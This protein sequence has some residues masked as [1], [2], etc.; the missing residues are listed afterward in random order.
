METEVKT[1]NIYPDTISNM[2]VMDWEGYATSE[3]FREGTETMLD[4]LIEQRMN[5]VLA[6][7]RTMVLIDTVDQKW[8]GTHFLPRAIRFGF[9]ACA[10]VTPT[11]YFNK[12]AVETISF[13]AEKEKLQIQFFDTAEEGKIWLDSLEF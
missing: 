9:K 3:Q 8:M 12:V 6:N 7:I 1:Y 2:I 5:K 13:K 4:L 10:I 11:S